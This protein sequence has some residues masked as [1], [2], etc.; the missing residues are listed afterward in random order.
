M[1]IMQIMQT[2]ALTLSLCLWVHSRA[3]LGS[4]KDVAHPMGRG[5][6]QVCLRW[7]GKVIITWGT[8]TGVRSSSSL[9]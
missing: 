2:C 3:V 6:A 7:R 8:L 1:Q 5:Q 4:K 9:L